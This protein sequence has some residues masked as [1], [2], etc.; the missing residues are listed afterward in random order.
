MHA[1]LKR[2]SIW[3]R[4]RALNFYFL[5][6]HTQWT[7]EPLKSSDNQFIFILGKMKIIPASESISVSIIKAQEK[8]KQLFF[9]PCPSS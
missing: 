9:L 3:E 1:V 4:E 5:T 7:K 6:L 8:K 2:K